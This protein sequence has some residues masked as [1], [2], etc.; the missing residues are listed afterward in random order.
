M[1]QSGKSN[2]D[3]LRKWLKDVGRGKFR[4]TEEQI[5][6]K[7]RLLERMEK[8]RADGNMSCDL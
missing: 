3:R 5:E 2:S 4:A 6:Q 8:E 1:R 7:R